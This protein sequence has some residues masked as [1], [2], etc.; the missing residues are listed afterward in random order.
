MLITSHWDLGCQ[1]GPSGKMKTQKVDL[2]KKCNHVA[3]IVKSTPFDRLETNMFYRS[4]FLSS[5]GYCLETTTYFDESEL[6]MM[7]SPPL[8]SMLSKMGYN[9]KTTARSIVYGPWR[10][11]GIDLHRLY[12][13]QGIG[14][15]Y[16]SSSSS[17]SRCRRTTCI[18]NVLEIALAWSQYCSGT[19]R[20]ILQA[21]SKTPAL[22]HHTCQIP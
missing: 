11:G 15:T 10:L 18:G 6:D 3:R 4:I 2:T 21:S 20:P 14:N 1:K 19:G 9:N 8:C 5:M 16:T 17:G 13:R 22:H 12:D 7:Q